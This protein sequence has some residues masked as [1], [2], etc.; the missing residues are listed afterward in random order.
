MSV[1]SRSFGSTRIR[2]ARL[3]SH[4]VVLAASAI[5]YGTAAEA[6]DS[7]GRSPLQRRA[8]LPPE[9]SETLT[10]SERKTRASSEMPT[11]HSLSMPARN[12][13]ARTRRAIDC[14][15]RT[16]TSRCTSG[17]TGVSRQSSRAFNSP[18]SRFGYICNHSPSI[19]PFSSPVSPAS[20]SAP[21]RRTRSPSRSWP[22]SWR[23][24]AAGITASRYPHP[25]QGLW[26]RRAVHVHIRRSRARS[27]SSG[28]HG[29]HRGD[30]SA[31]SR[32][33]CVRL[34]GCCVG[35]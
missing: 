4:L 31:E 6:S 18:V 2:E 25:D 34:R 32:I 3:G 22:R 9:R 5:S 29:R 26:R 14:P 33:S 1:F 10:R 23:P 20:I 28:C 17:P 13:P 16:A 35:R 27:G 15:L 19:L 8:L 30:R 24:G 11:G 12:R 21:S 7:S